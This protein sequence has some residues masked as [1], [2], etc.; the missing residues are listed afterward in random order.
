M[1]DEKNIIEEL[2]KN[3][4]SWDKNPKVQN[5]GIVEKNTDGVI[6]KHGSYGNGAG[7]GASMMKLDLIRKALQSYDVKD[8]DFILSVDS[9]VIFTSPEAFKYADPAYGI[10]GIKHRPE[11][12]TMRGLWSHM[13]GAQV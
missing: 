2:E 12:N 1:I 9:D 13:S 6:T 7:W 5:I 8:T 11:F 4:L 3:L 10:I